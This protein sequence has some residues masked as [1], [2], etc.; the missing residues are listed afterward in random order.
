MNLN[1]PTLR[2]DSTIKL[3]H[4]PSYELHHKAKHIKPIHFCVR[5]CVCER[6][7]T[8]EEVSTEEQLANILTKPVYK[9]MLIK[10]YNEFG[11]K[12]ERECYGSTSSMWHV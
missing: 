9:P 12:K 2:I 8:I 6:E 7:V 3:V 10:L 4:N 1:M 11:L 5:H